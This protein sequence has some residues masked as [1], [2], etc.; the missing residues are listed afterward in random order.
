MRMRAP[1][2]VGRDDEVEELDRILAAARK[3]QGSAVFV[4]GEPGIG[5]TRLAAEAVSHA[6]GA[7]MVVLR[8][9]GTAMG[10]AVP[11]RPLAEALLAV[12]RA[13]AIPD[14]GELGP[15]RSVLGRLV[16][17]WSDGSA[18]APD[19]SLIV[20]AEAV[21]RLTSVL[22][23]EHG[24]LLVLDDLQDAD[25]ETLAVVE[26]LS[27]NV[28]R[29]STVLLATVRNEPGDAYD[30]AMTAS[31]RPGSVGIELNRLDL[32]DVRRLV[33]SCLAADEADVPPDTARQLWENSAGNP[34]AVEELLHS[35]VS[36]RHLRK[37]AD[38]WRSI[39]DVRAE[40][41]AT[42]ARSIVGRTD[43][44]GPDGRA[45][46][47]VAAVLGR[48]FPL[49][50]VQRVAGVDDHTLL[51][52][53]RAGVTAQLV[54][55]DDGGPDWYRFQ[56]PLTAEALL[57][58]L[59][60]LDRAELSRRA[61][62][63][64]AAAHPGVPGEWCQLVARLRLDAGDQLAA[65]RL[66]TEAGRRA[67]ADGAGRSAL[68]LLE[69]A[70]HLVADGD[71]RNRADVLETLLYALAEAGH[72]ERVFELAKTLPS[73]AAG[74]DPARLA[75]LH[76]R[77]AWVA[78]MTGRVTDGMAQVAAARTL[79]GPDADDEATAEPD[80]V[81]AFLA[82]LGTGTERLREAEALARRAAAAAERAQLPMI[83]CQ[84]WFGVGTLVR[85]RDLAEAGRHFERVRTLA[86]QHRLA[87]WRLY[88]LC[89]LAGNDW[90]DRT[91]NTLLRDTEQEAL[92]AGA[93]TIAHNMEAI[94]GLD[95][96]LRG[97][98]AVAADRLKECGTSVRRLRL[99]SVDRYVRMSLA[100]LAAH[101][102]HRAEMDGHLAEF[103][104]I[105][106]VESQEYP[107][108]IGLARTF[109]ALLEEDVAQARVEL[110]TVVAVQAA[111]PTTFYLAGPHG[112]R[113]LLNVLAGTAGWPE[114]TAVTETAP[115]RM[116]WNRQFSLLAEA[117]L[118][119]RDGRVDEAEQ[120]VARAQQ[121]AE[122]YRMTR[123]LGLRLVAEAAFADGWG[124]PV[125][126]LRR[127]E[128]H[129]HGAG[130]TAVA[131]AC[132]G[133]LRQ[134]GAPVQQRR[135][136]TDR[137]PGDLRGLGV[138]VREFEVFELIARRL[139]NRAVADRLHIS[140]R[141]VEKHVASLLVKTGQPDR[142]RLMDYATNH[143]AVPPP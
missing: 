47:S 135:T 8:G 27:D 132:R 57:S 18:G 139:G 58:E 42:L 20:M 76:L 81:A 88:A 34:F 4:L 66:Y 67:L 14:D 91:D 59:T 40:V 78:H 77:L 51:T 60:P 19:G 98:F 69:R 82:M 102:G 97:D 87:I 125:G 96:V 12:G 95:A 17:D 5:K 113:L 2:L 32:P 30:L 46:L 123:R 41:P 122:P 129:F 90:L 89:A 100:T 15:Y 124:D 37:D 35:M 143:L 128:E 141:T 73:H 6:Y 114:Y 55:T 85:E 45:V 50:I 112:M 75:T 43:R 107:L 121:C 83:A 33:A 138:T 68:A 7:E 119:G 111:N 118:H 65:A 38:G 116:R 74:L 93:V 137:V 140:P 109:C 92:Q 29:Q 133:L 23:R 79:I 101:Q 49:S 11:F 1:Q 44:L 136:G 105:G 110:D 24:C 108:T 63:A 126:W 25:I 130:V 9:R 115:G 54:A 22:G 70:E 31:R 48:R 104:L 26:Y 56:H 120:A 80:A 13:G 64:V 94:Q 62:D 103:R 86:E 106:G 36:G 142:Q 52:N 10:P 28:S 39:R 16:P 61:A 71:V 3:G 134:F 53:I 131:I 21:L 99:V 117:V 72:F 84:A 127:A